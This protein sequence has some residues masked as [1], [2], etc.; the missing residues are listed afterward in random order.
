MGS[1]GPRT[2]ANMT[3][4]ANTRAVLRFEAIRAQA[5]QRADMSDAPATFQSISRGEVVTVQRV[6]HYE[7]GAVCVVAT[8]DGRVGECTADVLEAI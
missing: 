7:H 8:D 6:E 2:K 3:I 5:N 1:A 4:D